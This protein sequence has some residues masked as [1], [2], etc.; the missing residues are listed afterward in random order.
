MPS[1]SLFTQPKP[2]TTPQVPKV[3]LE[4]VRVGV[5]I[6]RLE[7]KGG[8]SRSRA[9]HDKKGTATVHAIR[10][11]PAGIK[12]RDTLAK[13]TTNSNETTKDTSKAL[14][15]KASQL[16]RIQ[17]NSQAR[18]ETQINPE[19]I[20]DPDEEVPARNPPA[21]FAFVTPR[22][23][24]LPLLDFIAKQ[25]SA[26]EKRKG[27][28]G[29]MKSATIRRV[30]EEM[31]CAKEKPESPKAGQNGNNNA[32]EVEPESTEKVRNIVEHLKLLT[33]NKKPPHRQQTP[34]L[35]AVPAGRSRTEQ[36]L[37]LKSASP[38]LS[39][40]TRTVV[41]PQQVHNNK[42]PPVKQGR[43]PGSAKAAGATQFRF[44]PASPV[45]A[46]HHR[47]SVTGGGH[48]QREGQPKQRTKAAK[49]KERGK[50]ARVLET[51]KAKIRG[52]VRIVEEQRE[53]IR[54]LTAAAAP[55]LGLAP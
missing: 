9:E 41:S 7:G 2:P 3:L 5:G 26:G 10:L 8:D 30:R 34:K 15:T 24:A 29:D 27:P 17:Q 51:M 43:I 39:E 6:G 1:S 16:R 22:R 19:N 40:K 11:R 33:G 28:V 49:G 14:L 55:R 45:L 48:R 18:R 31:G 20:D 21:V 25:G 36:V 42:P 47:N 37:L 4:E 50:M 38:V 54:V 13:S 12:N 53:Q 44:F 35:T 23:K 52:L 32:E 46:V